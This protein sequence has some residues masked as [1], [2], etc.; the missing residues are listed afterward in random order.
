M[1]ARAI[2]RSATDV[3]LSIELPV[4][5]RALIGDHERGVRAAT[6]PTGGRAPEQ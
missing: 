6:R 4:G 5:E 1:P 2:R 3:D